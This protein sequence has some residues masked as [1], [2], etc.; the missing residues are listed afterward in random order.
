VGPL[1]FLRTIHIAFLHMGVYE[2]MMSI[3][4]ASPQ[5]YEVCQ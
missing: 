2:S 4:L 3:R 5:L 1:S